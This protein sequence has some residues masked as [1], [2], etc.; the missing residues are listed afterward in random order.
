MAVTFDKA[1]SIATGSSGAS[2]TI[3]CAANAVLFAFAEVAAG[4]V[5]AMT[6]N[7]T[8]FTSLGGAQTQTLQAFIFSAPPTG[9]STFKIHWPIAIQFSVMLAS[10]TGHS[11]TNYTGNCRAQSSGAA[12]NFNVSV[13][14]TNGDMVI[15]GFR[16][17][18]ATADVVTINNGTTRLA[19]FS[20]SSR[21]IC[22]LADIAGATSITLSATCVAAHAWDAIAIP[23][24]AS[25]GLIT[26]IP[27]QNLLSVGL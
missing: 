23:L 14:A 3:T 1:W 13:S 21:A 7:G 24:H 27:L 16:V 18:S 12:N 9:V 26:V 19:P 15:V 25:V 10:Y 20:D 8:S 2:L 17:T 22:A 5:S 4:S 11:T 6:L